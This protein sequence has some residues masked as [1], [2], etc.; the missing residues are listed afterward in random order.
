MTY[1]Y[2]RDNTWVLG[3]IGI[4]ILVV[5]IAVAGWMMASHWPPEAMARAAKLTEDT[6][7]QAEEWDAWKQDGLP[8]VIQT[9]AEEEART[10]ATQHAVMRG[11][12]I[13]GLGA[14]VVFGAIWLA[15]RRKVAAMPVWER[16]PDSALLTPWS[17]IDIRTGSQLWLDEPREADLALLEGLGQYKANNLLAAGQILS[18]FAGATAEG[19]SCGQRKALEW[20]I[21]QYAD[22]EEGQRQ[23]QLVEVQ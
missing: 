8:V 6:R 18:R 19:L 12:M 23:K 14:T 11:F 7:E 17:V 4:L 5:A 2:S 16:L 20:A 10:L 9:K 1:Y 13:F 15:R 3:A 21:K 22:V